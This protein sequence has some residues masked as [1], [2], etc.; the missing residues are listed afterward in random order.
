MILHLHEQHVSCLVEPDFVRFVE[1]RFVGRAT[2]ACITAMSASGH[3]ADDSGARNPPDDMVIHFREVDGTVGTARDAIR[4]GDLCVRGGAIISRVTRHPC[5]RKCFDE[6][7]SLSSPP[8]SGV[9]NQEIEGENSHRV[10]L[11]T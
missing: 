5:A 6:G 2:V 4:V 3:G 7:G 9:K 10:L 8:E 11:S 1:Q